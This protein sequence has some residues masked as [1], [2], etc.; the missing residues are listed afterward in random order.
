MNDLPGG[1]DVF[2]MLLSAVIL[3][4]IGFALEAASDAKTSIPIIKPTQGDTE[5]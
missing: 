5:K 2:L 3:A 4:G 1:R